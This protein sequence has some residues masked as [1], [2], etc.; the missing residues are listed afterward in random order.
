[1]FET[2]SWCEG[3]SCAVVSFCYLIEE[4]A[5]GRQVLVGYVPVK[6]HA[7]FAW[8]C[9]PYFGW[10][11]VWVGHHTRTLECI[12]LLICDITLCARFCYLEL[13]WVT[14]DWAALGITD[15]LASYFWRS[16]LYPLS[17]VPTTSVFVRFVTVDNTNLAAVRTSEARMTSMYFNGGLIE[18]A[19]GWKET[20]S[21][22]CH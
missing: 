13:L 1:M 19:F 20:S 10:Q 5:C 7:L 18:S 14:T 6:W 3:N 12:G 15:L 2:W 8:S 22:L 9:I 17:R 4:R 16:L 21:L 11:A